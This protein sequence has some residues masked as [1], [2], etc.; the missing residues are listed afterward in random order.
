MVGIVNPKTQIPKPKSQIPMWDLGLGT[1]GR[2]HQLETR[3]LSIAG[4]TSSAA[5]RIDQRRGR[6]RLEIDFRGEGAAGLRNAG[7]AG[8][9]IDDGRSAD[10]QEHITG[11]SLGR[12]FDVP[13]VERFTE[14]HDRGT[15][16]A[17]AVRTSRQRVGRG[18]FVSPCAQTRSAAVETPDLPQRTMKTNQIACAGAEVK[19]I[20]V[21]GNDSHL[22]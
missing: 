20:D 21:L 15:G 5:P 10:R 13:G 8:R 18:V 3:S 1:W 6:R 2:M 17:A 9:G 12:V 14:P 16:K 22:S 7:E 11:C 4:N 19:V